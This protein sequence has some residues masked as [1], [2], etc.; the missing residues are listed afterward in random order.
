MTIE[1]EI[2]GEP[3]A[4]GRPRFARRGKFVTT[5]TPKETLNFEQLV[6]WCAK[7]A[8]ADKLRG[9]VEVSAKFYF[10]LPKHKHRKTKPVEAKPKTTKPDLDN[11]I[12]A[13]LDGL[14]NIAFVDDAAVWK[15][16]F[17]EKWHCAQDEVPRTE[18]SLTNN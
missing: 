16:S 5:Y 18:I 13:I 15:F 17:I 4:K 6:G 10:R 12:K 14:N 1:F 7:E 9:P 11:L 2:P 8:G 3:V